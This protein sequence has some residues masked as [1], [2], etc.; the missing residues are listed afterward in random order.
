MVIKGG[1]GLAR[2]R[3]RCWS[4]RPSQRWNLE[5]ARKALDAVTSQ[6]GEVR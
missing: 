1:F 6:R 2:L 3:C 4:S 5:A